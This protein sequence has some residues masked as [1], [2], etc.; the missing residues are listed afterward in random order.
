MNTRSLPKICVA[1]LAIAATAQALSAATVEETVVNQIPAA[2]LK[3]LV[4]SNVNGSIQCIGKDTDT[5]ELA[6]KIKVKASS[7][8]TAQE[9]YDK[10]NIAIEEKGGV[11]VVDTKLPKNKG[12]GFWRWVSGNNINAS[13]E[14]LVHVPAGLDVKLESVNGGVT[15]SDIAGQVD[16]ETV[17]GGIKA[18]GLS[19][20]ADVETVNGGINV[21]FSE[22]LVMQDM[23]FETVNGGVKVK[24]PGSAAF[25]VKVS[26]VNGGIGCDFDLPS[27]AVKKRR[28]LDAKINGGGPRIR[29]ETVNGGVSVQKS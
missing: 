28:D 1:F 22:S 4:L 8:E 7:E 16:L 14:Y 21:E 13:V 25:H 29:I 26:T 6:C 23:S 11:L 17:N 3:S 15:V 10:I 20:S 19:G 2:A 5:I 9:Y 12:G 27:D 24:L 18:S